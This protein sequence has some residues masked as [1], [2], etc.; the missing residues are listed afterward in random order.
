M[1]GKAEKTP[2]PGGETG[3]TGAENIPHPG[4]Y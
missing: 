4:H 3:K 1:T 2:R